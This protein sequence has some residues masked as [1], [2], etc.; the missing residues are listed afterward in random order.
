MHV[1]GRGGVYALFVVLVFFFLLSTLFDPADKAL[2]L[3]MPLYLAC[4]VVG[5]LACVNR[6]GVG[7]PL[8]LLIYIMLMVGVPMTSL[9]YYYL[10]N[11]SDP[12]KGFELLKAYVFVSFSALIYITRIDILKY[13]CWALSLLAVSVLV[14]TAVVLVFP[15]FYTPLYLLGADLGMFNIDSG[16]DYGADVVLFQMFFVTSPMLVISVAHYFKLAVT[17]TRWRG[18]YAGWTVLHIAALLVAGSRSNIVGALALPLIL[19]VFFSTNRL[20]TLWWMA[21][22]SMLFSLVFRREI[23]AMLDPVE[24]SNSSKLIMIKDYATILSDPLKLMLGS[25]LG[26]YDQWTEKGYNYITELTLLEI[27]RNFGLLLGGLMVLL[28]LYPI[29]HAFVLRRGET[30]KH[31]VLAFA[32]YLLMSL[33]NPLLFSSMGM[34]FLGVVMANLYLADLKPDSATRHLITVRDGPTR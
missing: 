11:G 5:C 31:A 32:V 25:G 1:H 14:L 34:L 24:S 21:M 29:V 20:R 22:A 27:F 23:G 17:S 28:L 18:F 9:S 8:G 33:T 13:L 10:V 7:V 15:E 4:W 30:E 19:A 6:P 2:G 3:K 16:R 12:F 26:A